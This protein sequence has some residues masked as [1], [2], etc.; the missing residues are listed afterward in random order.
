MKCSKHFTWA[1][2]ITIT[3]FNLVNVYRYDKTGLS[4]AY[5]FALLGTLLCGTVGLHRNGTSRH[6]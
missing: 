1:D 3:V 5:D 4:L 6:E 2:Q